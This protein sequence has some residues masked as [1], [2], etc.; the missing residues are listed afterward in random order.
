MFAGWNWL[1]SKLQSQNHPI[2]KLGGIL[3]TRYNSSLK[4]LG[5]KLSPRVSPLTTPSQI[6]R[7]E[8]QGEPAKTRNVI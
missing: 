8:N 1:M 3:V 6:L 7:R 2:S 4:M 5:C